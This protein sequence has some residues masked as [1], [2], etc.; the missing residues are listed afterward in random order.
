MYSK[1]NFGK[2]ILVQVFIW[3]IIAMEIGKGNGKVFGKE[4]WHLFMKII[5]N[6]RKGR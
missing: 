1:I 5:E 2:T 4:K 6:R 3:F